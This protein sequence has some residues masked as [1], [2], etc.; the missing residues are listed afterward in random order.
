V[1]PNAAQ[2]G[3]AQPT[4][5]PKPGGQRPPKTQPDTLARP[6]RPPSVRVPS[7]AAH[8]G[9]AEGIIPGVAFVPGTARLENSSYVALDS[10]ADL[11]RAAPDMR[12]EVGAHT[13]NTGSAADAARITSLQAEAVRDYLVVKGVNYQQVVARGYGFAVPLTPDT[14]PRGRAANRRVEIR[15]VVGGP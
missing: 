3:A 9:I 4:A 15:L 12:V 1:R 2:P 13:D 7:A 14:T 5:A 11:L 10:I 8:G 6:L